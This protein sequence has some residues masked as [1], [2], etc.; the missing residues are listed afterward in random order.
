MS[1]LHEIHEI[2]ERVLLVSVEE[3][4]KDDTEACLD[5]LEELAKTAGASVVGR[6]VQKREKIHPG[7][8]IGKGKIEELAT[9]VN[10]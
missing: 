5:E 2:E 7:T 1:G 4:P 6:M 10:E 8:Y 9:Y 3:N